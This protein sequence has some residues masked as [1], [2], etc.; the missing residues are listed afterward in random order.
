MADDAAWA[1]GVDIGK[2]SKYSRNKKTT[3]KDTKEKPATEKEKPIKIGDFNKGNT[4]AVPSS[5]KKG[6]RV[7]KTGLA[8]VHKGEKILTV[9]QQKVAGIK[10]GKR[11]PSVYKRVAGKG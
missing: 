2:N 10:K 5:Y 1:A 7:K 11:K 4:P 6:G 3:D 9:A 8:K